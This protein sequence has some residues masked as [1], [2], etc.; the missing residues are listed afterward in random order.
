MKLVMAEKPSVG[1]EY[2]K[3]LGASKS[4][5]GYME[6]NDWVVT[7]GFGHLVELEDP[8]YYL[9]E[10]LRGVWKK[11][12]LPILV[13]DFVFRIKTTRNKNT[14]KAETDSGAK[15]QLNIIKNLFKRSDVEYLVNGTDAGREGEAIFRY[16]YNFLGVKKTVKRLWTSSLTDTALKKAFGELKDSKD[17]D[18][19]FTAALC[20]NE[21]D[22]LVG[23]NAT[24]ALSI[25][26]SD[27]KEPLSVGRVQTPT[28]AMICE[29][30]EQYVNFKPVPYYVVKIEFK[31]INGE[32][33]NV[34]L[35]EKFGERQKAEDYIKTLPEKWDVKS[36]EEKEVKEKAPLP[37]CIDDVQIKANQ[38]YGMKAQQTLDCVQS[39]YEAKM[40]TYPRTGSRY[41]GEDMV[42]M[43]GEGVAKLA[44]LGYSNKFVEACQS[45]N[46]SNVNKAMFD[47][48]KLT[49]HHAIIPTFENFKT[50]TEEF[51]SI[52]KGSVTA[53][54]LKRVYDLIVKQLV[55]ASMPV[56][57]KNKLTY[58]L[59]GNEIEVNVSGFT[60]KD[61]GWRSILGKDVTEE[62][63]A[64]EEDNQK[65]PDLKEGENVEVA[66]KNVEDKQTTPEPILTEATLLKLMEGAGK[67]IDDEDKELKKA[68]KDCGIGT[69]ATRAAAIETLFNRGYVRSEGKKLIPT[70]KG[71]DFYH[72]V[73]NEDVA[74]VEMTAEW[75]QKLKLV[76]EGKYSSKVFM[77]EI[78][79]YTKDLVESLL[80]VNA[81]AIR[82]NVQVSVGECPLC[83]GA[84]RETDR[85][86]IC[87]NRKKDDPSTCRFF[88][89][90][91]FVPYKD[92]KTT[93]KF[94]KKDLQKLIKLEE[95][96]EYQVEVKP[97]IVASKKFVYSPQSQRIQYATPKRLETE[98]NC[99][100]CGGKIIETDKQ[101]KCE[102]NNYLKED[103]C[104]IC[105]FKDT[106][107]GVTLTEKMV[108][109]LLAGDKLEKIKLT[110]KAG[111]KYEGTLY[112][113]LDSY[114][115]K[116]YQ[117][118][119]D[120]GLVCP[121]CGGKIIET[122][123]KY[124]CE[125]NVYGDESSCPVSLFKDQG[126]ILTV[127]MVK[128]LLEGKETDM[129]TLKGKTG[130]YE[131]SLKYDFDANKVVKV[132]PEKKE[133][134]VIDTGL[135]CKC[136]GKIQLV[137]DKFYTCS[138]HNYRDP[139]TC[140][141][142]T[143]KIMSSK[144][145]TVE[146]L[147]EILEKGEI[148]LDGFKSKVGKDFSAKLVLKKNKIE[149]LFDKK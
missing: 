93:V 72:V 105:L 85:F 23:M 47:S 34:V 92:C 11:E 135:I 114:S 115:I 108:S 128:L 28:M 33:F 30:Y 44:V 62:E 131:A 35:P 112:Y 1:R 90:K 51:G 122:D 63:K 77:D 65:L 24:R 21:S 99:P 32:K 129:L 19:L 101:F 110:S 91:T 149:F 87:V 15:K 97:G 52:A 106:R 10:A 17:Y 49:D 78:V 39:L 59:K 148:E 102:N 5:D 117:E 13:D 57:V 123:M 139:K 145:I 124:H 50:K 103:S 18:D 42:E 109:T 26:A 100:K 81:D 53:E 98:I 95:T 71:L 96:S 14:K 61:E 48:S 144:E 104:P 107:M 7:W 79:D 46:A 118:K 116:R 130:N 88:L 58:I 36:K 134:K 132:F 3:L 125:N 20:R 94:K 54:D 147:K 66:N 56:C 76:E 69:P 121:K 143:S 4:Y 2:A 40:V 68:I 43:V 8:D 31:S 111:T 41:L 146:I 55:M 133:R 74:K 82:K 138:N 16:V 67:L 75:E 29:R 89:G 22:W 86:Y 136:G 12:Q 9:D 137:D 113:D 6:G 119:K 142:S 60:I 64:K 140:Q 120:T 38:L 70:D 27:G 126:I 80:Q 25:S 37:F 127:D 83:H 45:V 84:I 73:K 141:F